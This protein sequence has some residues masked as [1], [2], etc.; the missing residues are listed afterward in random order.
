MAFYKPSGP[1]SY[2]LLSFR[3]P[4][5]LVNVPDLT[6]QNVYQTP[7]MHRHHLLLSSSRNPSMSIV[8]PPPQQSPKQM[9]KCTDFLTLLN[10]II[11]SPQALYRSLS[12]EVVCLDVVTHC[13]DLPISPKDIP[14]NLKMKNTVY[15][16]NQFFFP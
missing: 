2:P 4:L 5:S 11:K 8:V 10:P 9:L 7:T 13:L 12:Y 1:S 3:K 15:T 6:I 16:L 14:N